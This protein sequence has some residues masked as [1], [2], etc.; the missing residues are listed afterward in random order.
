MATRARAKP[1]EVIAPVKG[2]IYNS[3]T[4]FL[5]PRAS[6]NISNMRLRLDQISSAPGYVAHGDPSKILGTPQLFI[7]YKENDGD[8]HFLAFTTKYTYEF[9]T[10]LNNWASI[11]SRSIILSDA[12]SNWTA[13][14][15]VTSA[16]DAVD[17]L[18]D[19]NSVKL[20]IDAAFTTG[21]AAFFD[22][23][24]VD[25][26]TYSHV[27]FWIKS[28]IATVAGD[29]E[30]QI[31]DTAGCVSPLVS[32]ALPALVAGDWTEVEI[33]LGAG[34]NAAVVSVGINVVVDN[35]AQVLNID[36]V[37]AA[38]R[39]TGTDAD[40]WSVTTYLDKFYATNGVDAIQEKDHSLDF[41]DFASAVAAGFKAKIIDEF[42]NHLILVNTIEAGV[43]F[44]QRYRW[45]D[46]A[47]TSFVAGT[48]GSTEID[49]EDF[50][51]ALGK[52]GTR[53]IIYK[54][55]SIAVASFIGGNTVF[56]F[57]VQITSTG[58]LAQN[59]R[60]AIN[61]NEAF[62]S[63]ENVYLYA[64]GR[65]LVAIGDEIREEMFRIISDSEA[66]KSWMYYDKH[67]QE[68]YIGMVTETDVYPN[69]I[70]I[71]Q[72]DRKVWSRRNRADITALG[73]FSTTQ[74]I[75]YG[76]AIGTYG[77]QTGQY[78]NRTASSL[79]P[80]IVG[81][82]SSGQVFTI[83]ETTTDDLGVLV[84]KIFDSPDLV[85]QN[86]PLLGN[87]AVAFTGNTKM[88][89]GLAFEALGD[90]V[91]VYF[92]VDSGNTFILLQ[93]VALTGFF[94]PYYISTHINSERLRYRFR[95]KTLGGVL[96]IRWYAPYV[97]GRSR[98]V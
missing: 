64:G 56:R 75:T 78:G 90:E 54:E 1:T 51:I 73:T 34:A 28:D 92:S 38:D 9:S 83:D 68:L 18:R 41:D 43:E 96:Q 86:L 14:A 4:A 77:V 15:N 48:A 49:G 35:G 32:L 36:D 67:K 55:D 65:E 24:A 27:H 66:T 72:R 45:T 60:A 63:K 94:E 19:A 6:T 46:S 74:G 95:N 31:D 76:Q 7:E 53:H 91:E 62:V 17:F 10:L 70:W 29:L 82:S 61:E 39:Y 2:L 16:L 11:T 84:D 89:M 87:E 22:F 20:T 33:A 47:S 25:T 98:I 69:T 12:E 80:I 44:P 3:Q 50:I 42:R 97:I 37:R 57:D 93:T 21:L 5:D 59:L 71:W 26:T 58:L 85:A 8:T 40:L 81:A 13:S 88:W 30:I 79:S 52:S 23:G